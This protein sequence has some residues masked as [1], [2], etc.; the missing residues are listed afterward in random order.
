MSHYNTCTNM[1]TNSYFKIRELE[2]SDYDKGYLELLNQL[3]SSDGKEISL[4]D[5]FS[6]YQIVKSNPGH[7]I[8]VIEDIEENKII[9]TCTLLIEPKFL[10]GLSYVGH[11][12]D[13]VVDTNNRKYGYGKELLEYVNQKAK[14]QEC[15]KVILDCDYK[16]VEYYEKR[17]YERK[18]LQMAI[19]F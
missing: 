4:K 18:G 6:H 15:Y 10:R 8:F 14:E 7:Y 9:A 3:S 12:E 19:Y 13:L 1:N 11:I 5:F 16:L 2:E 17:G